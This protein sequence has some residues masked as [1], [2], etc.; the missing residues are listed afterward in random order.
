[1]IQSH[2]GNHNR[3][4]ISYIYKFVSFNHHF[5]CNSNLNIATQICSQ[6]IQ[7][8]T[9]FIKPQ[10]R[11]SRFLISQNRSLNS[12]RLTSPSV[13]E[14]LNLSLCHP[15]ITIIQQIPVDLVKE[16]SMVLPLASVYSMSSQRF[17]S[18]HW[19]KGVPTPRCT[20]WT[21]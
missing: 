14:Q 18:P 20:H 4:V 2:C 10:Y 12:T 13:V 5:D 7:Q 15:Q 1:M 21:A 6:C 19:A 16:F 8:D 17:L 9:H 3:V 11:A